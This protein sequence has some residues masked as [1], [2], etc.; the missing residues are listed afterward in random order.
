[1]AQKGGGVGRRRHRLGR[2]DGQKV[3]DGL[4][5]PGNARDLVLRRLVGGQTPQLGLR[6]RPGLLVVVLPE[7]YNESIHL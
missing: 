6:R 1:M 5:A 3:H 2:R 4:R 7:I